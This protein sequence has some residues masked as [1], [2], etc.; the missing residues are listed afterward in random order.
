M[1]IGLLIFVIIGGAV[2]IFST[3]Y[4]V[5]SLIYTIFQKIYRKIKYNIS[6]FD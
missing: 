3:G 1:N 5:I 6:L 4:M 2:G